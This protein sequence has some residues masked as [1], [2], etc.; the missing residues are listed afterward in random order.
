MLRALGV[1]LLWVLACWNARG[2]MVGFEGLSVYSQGSNGRYYNGD[3][4]T[5]TTNTLGWSSDGVHFSNTFAYDDVNK[6]SFWSGFAYSRETS[7]TVGGFMNQYAARPGSGSQ[8]STQYA[9]VYN[10][11]QGDAIVTFGA[12]VQLNTVDISNTAYTYYSM[13]NGD[14]FAK[15]FGGDSGNDADFFKLSIVGVRGG[16]TTGAVDFYLADYR[17]ADNSQDYIIKDW[18]TVGLSG[19]GT[20]DALQF[21]LSS[22]DNGNFG[23]NTPAYFAMDQ[24]SFASVPEPGSMGLV[25]AASAVGM[26]VRRRRRG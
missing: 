20:V 24:L 23:M 9:I 19:L 18:T 17:S 13:L 11:L 21:A 12:A 26:W 10:G 22:S 5:N 6:W 4:G 15:K 14:R 7:G 1:G 3:Q 16:V 8:G 2:D 25:L